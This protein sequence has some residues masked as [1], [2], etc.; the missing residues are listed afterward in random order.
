MEE[1]TKNIKNVKN[2][3]RVDVN[4]ETEFEKTQFQYESDRINEELD[5]EDEIEEVITEEERNKRL[6]QQLTAVGLLQFFGSKIQSFSHDD[7]GNFS[8][9]FNNFNKKNNK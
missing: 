5:L 3:K 4:A 1:E 2:V 8:I 7:Q 6:A 9:K